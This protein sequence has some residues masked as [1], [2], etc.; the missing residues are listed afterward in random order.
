MG[1]K[2]NTITVADL[3]KNPSLNTETGLGKDFLD[4]IK[5]Y[6][7]AL[8][9]VMSEFND[10]L[11]K[12]LDKIKNGNPTFIENDWYL[13][14]EYWY[15]F[16][17]S[18]LYNRDSIELEKKIIKLFE[19]NINIIEKRLIEDNSERIEIIKELFTLYKNKHYFS[20]INLA[21]SLVEGISIKKFNTKF[22]GW[23]GDNQT[24][25]L[26]TEKIKS[27]VEDDTIFNFIEKRLKHRG[28]MNA[29]IDQ[30]PNESIPN[31]NNRH[32]IAHGESYLYGN[33]PNAVKS[34][35]LV[36]FISSLKINSNY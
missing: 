9:D 20:L 7:Q 18:E 4:S 21:Y 14:N 1:R 30:I 6:T 24:G 29:S 35:L 26:R 11:K 2:V 25:K 13:S 36:E 32:C 8:N 19:D 16:N 3:R 22:W 31:S 10:A 23:E 34:I 17:I 12:S 33:K 5:K 15:D 27:K 28:I